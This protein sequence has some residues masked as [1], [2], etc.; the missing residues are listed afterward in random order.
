MYDC[1]DKKIVYYILNKIKGF[2]EID[3][4]VATY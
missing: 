2:G 4:P 1:V 3:I